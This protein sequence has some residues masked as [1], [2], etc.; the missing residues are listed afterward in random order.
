MARFFSSSTN[1]MNTSHHPNELIP[2]SKILNNQS[3]VYVKY[4]MQFFCV[5]VSESLVRQVIKCRR[6]VVFIFKIQN[7]FEFGLITRTR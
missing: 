3:G 6:L 7:L 4:S 5:K 2:V 1:A